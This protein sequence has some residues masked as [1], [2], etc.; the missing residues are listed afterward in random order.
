MSDA[1]GNISQWKKLLKKKLPED[2]QIQTVND[3]FNA[4]VVYANDLETWNQ[5][6]YWA[7]PL[8]LLKA[9][10]GDCEDFAIAKYFTLRLL[11]VSDSKLRLMYARALLMEGIISHMVLTYETPNGIMVLDNLIGEVKSI[12]HRADLIAVYTFNEEGLYLPS[13]KGELRTSDTKNMSRW[14]EVLDKMSKEGYSL[15]NLTELQ[16][17]LS[18]SAP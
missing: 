7:T 9:G 13:V 3:F 18:E 5:T 10:A 6:D 2:E 17:E 1:K 11:G 15:P 16:P 4:S 12:A 8:E 14:Q